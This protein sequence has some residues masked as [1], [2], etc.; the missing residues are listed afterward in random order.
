MNEQYY[1]YLYLDPRKSG[2]F[3]YNELKFDFEPFYVGKGKDDRLNKHL[4]YYDNNRHK[5]NKIKKILKQGLNPII[6]KLYENLDEKTAIEKEIY[7]ISKIGRSDKLIGPLT[8]LTNGGEGI[9]GYKFTQEFLDRVKKKVIKYDKIGNILDKYKTVEEASEKN[10]ISKNSVIRCCNGDVKFS[11]N[12]YIYLYDNVKFE[13]RNK[14]DGNKYPV[15]SMDKNGDDVYYE[16]SDEA[17]I[18]SGINKS[19]I[20]A[21]CKGLRF[22]AGGYIW[23]YTKHPKIELYTK[24]IEDKWKHLIPFLNKIIVDNNGIEYKN[25]LHCLENKSYNTNGVIRFLKNKELI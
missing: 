11:E 1:I 19:N 4:G 10:N 3:T 8:N 9:S 5:S 12:K 6:I 23:R 25:I 14:L 17:S 2:K 13:P 18:I 20:N 22:Q 15:M 7:I 24:Q 21:T 16:S